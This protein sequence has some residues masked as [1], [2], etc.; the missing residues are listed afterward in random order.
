MII[1]FNTRINRTETFYFDFIMT[2]NKLRLYC[3]LFGILILVNCKKVE[4]EMLVATGS[5]SN[6]TYNSAKITGKI[7]D[8]GK[9]ATQHGHYCSTKSGET[10][11]GFWTKLNVPSKLGE[12]SSDLTGLN[13]STKYY[14]KAYMSNG[15]DTIYGNE[16][17]FSTTTLA[18]PSAP[19]I[20]GATAGNAQA[21]VSFT[22]P[23]NNG[24]SPVTGYTATSNPGG[25]TASSSASPIT[26]LGL[27]N[28]ITY[29]FTVYATNENGNSATSPASNS[30]IP[31]A[32][33]DA[34]TTVT[35]IAGNAQATISFIA[36][37]NNGGS[38]ITGYTV[39]STPG[40][41]TASGSASP[42]VITG[43]TNGIAYTFTV[44]AKNAS[45]NS[46]PSSVSNSVTPSTV[47]GAPAIGTVTGG[48]AQ[49]TVS[50]TAPGSNGGSVITGYVVT[51]NPG[52]FTASGTASPIIVTGL[53]NGTSYTFTV[54]ATN[55]NGNSLPSSVS[56]S[57]TPSTIPGSPAIGTAI[58]GNAQA[59]ISFTAPGSNG[60]SSIT[61]YTVTSSPGGLTASE[62]TSPITITGLTNGITYSFTVF[63]TNANGNSLPSPN[64]N[65][66]TPSTPSTVYDIDGNAYGIVTIGSQVW[67][68]ENLKT[69]K[70][71][72]DTPIPYETVGGRWIE[73]LTGAYCDY[74][75][76]PANS[77]IYGR[78]YNW[79]AVASTNPKNVCPA[80]WHVPSDEEWT[81]LTNYLGGGSIAGGKLKESG[82][83]HWIDP[84]TGATNETGFTALPGGERYLNGTFYDIGYL[85][86]WWSSTIHISTY[87]Y[88]V[89]M[90]SDNSNLN[91]TNTNVVTGKSVRCLKDN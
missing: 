66:V 91:R 78:L 83:A 34:P 54:V 5:V 88:Y 75:N 33:P 20:V 39:T 44:I 9:G 86:F 81:F 89:Y 11:S 19:T 76:T 70:Y 67:M 15:S 27:T 47:P 61:G 62:L 40:D 22:A 35:A 7:I 64:S 59:T 42:I 30:V 28:G 49:A 38:S 90:A 41:L 69:T 26:I 29:T 8:I 36:P 73:L 79:Y 87:A 3:F 57:V 74:L 12:F 37:V 25:I 31:S 53:A 56:N 18:P 51:S 72:D 77:A 84:N 13:S 6:I 10:K 21:T 80:G 71:N 45:G 85:G 52:G 63:A 24:G 65:L 82:F 46:L 50:F 17:S 58:A 32:I 60:G 43:L 23:G 14:A 68:N 2:G 55:T 48:N 16:I 4:K 1:K